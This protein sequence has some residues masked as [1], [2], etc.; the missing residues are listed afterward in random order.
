MGSGANWPF[1]GQPRKREFADACGANLTDQALA[2]GI[3]AIE[4]SSSA[5]RHSHYTARAEVRWLHRQ[6]IR[7][8]EKQTILDPAA[9]SRRPNA[10]PAKR[11]L[12]GFP[13]KQQVGLLAAL[14][15]FRCFLEC[16]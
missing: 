12:M 2:E 6:Q 8:G 16:R 10:I 11:A 9:A 13:L 3:I 1:E 5:P 7:V 15:F 4:T 14:G